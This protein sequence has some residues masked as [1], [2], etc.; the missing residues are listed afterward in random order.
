MSESQ[1]VYRPGDHPKDCYYVFEGHRELLTAEEKRAWRHL[2]LLAKARAGGAGGKSCL[3]RRMRLNR[4][5]RVEGVEGV[6]DE[7]VDFLLEG[8]DVAFFRRTLERIVRENPQGL[9]TCPRCGSLC[10]TRESC[11]CPHCSHRWHQTRE[12]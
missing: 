9:N 6:E 3:A 4:D 1:R 7:G 5:E 10:R 11:L 8:G 2:Q 12:A